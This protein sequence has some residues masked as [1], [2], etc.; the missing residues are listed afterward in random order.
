MQHEIVAVLVLRHAAHELG[1]VPAHR[2]H[3]LQDVH[4]AVLDDLLDARIGRAVHATP[5]V[6]VL[7][8]DDDG[9]VVAA[10]SPPL[11]H[12]HE[13]DEGVGGGGHLVV[14]GPARELEQL[15]A[16]RGRLH[17][18]HQ[19]RQRHDLLVDPEDPGPDVGV[20]VVR[21]V[22]NGEDGAVLLGMP[23]LGPEGG[24][25]LRVLGWHAEDDDGR[26][27]VVV[28]H[29]PKVALRVLE[30]PLRHDVLSRLRVA[31]DEHGV[32]VV[33]EVVALE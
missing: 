13:L 24:I 19:L 2:P 6:T 32:D 33:G 14:H 27:L 8:D 7:A 3:G 21:D 29:G 12:V 18:C 16:P 28:D 11:H 25:R 17:A 31:V 30:R 26:R 10:L 22:V 5:T 4:L 23:S 1:P 15:D 9:A 20:L